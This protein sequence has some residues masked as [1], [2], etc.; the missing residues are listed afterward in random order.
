[1]NDKI[2]LL[3][4][5]IKSYGQVMVAF[6][7]GV[8]STFLLKI[9]MDI[10]GEKNVTAVTGA[11]ETY[12]PEELDFAVKTA[13]ELNV[14]HII[15]RTDEIGDENFVSNTEL[16]CYHCKKNFYAKLREKALAENIQ[17]ILDGTN[18]DDSSD[19]RPGRKAA[20]EFG[21]LSPLLEAGLT[22]NEIR[23]HSKAIGLSSWKPCSLRNENY[24]RKA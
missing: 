1:M 8:D 9:C 2:N 15:I 3:K 7:G 19:Y 10:L 17:Y 6:S 5:K 18:Q 21:I 14:R 4:T 16:R 13:A 20:S 22:K 24:Q 23:L 11:S 12:T